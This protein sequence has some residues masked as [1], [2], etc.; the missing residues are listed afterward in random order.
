MKVRGWNTIFSCIAVFFWL[1]PHLQCADEWKRVYLASYPRSGNHWMRYLIEEAVHIATGSV[2]CDNDPP[3]LQEP[4]PWGGYCVDHGY[5]GTCRYPSKGEVVV[6]KTHYPC[7]CLQQFDK[8]PYIKVVRILRNP[9]DSIYSWHVY[10]SC[11]I[12]PIPSLSKKRLVKFIAKWRNFNEYWDRQHDVITIRYEDLYRRPCFV[13][14]DVLKEIGYDVKMEDIRRAVAK[15]PPGGG[16][17][18]HI[19]KYQPEDLEMIF[20]EL[21]DLL[22]DYGYTGLDRLSG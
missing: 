19:D 8:R 3:H 2:Y 9:V 16:L 6:I 15:Y 22:E 5:E 10:E 11:G 17:F 21:E 13:L 18:K 7:L 1:I 14:R 20:E 12:Q 4:F